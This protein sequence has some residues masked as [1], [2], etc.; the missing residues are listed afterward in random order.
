MKGGEGGGGSGEER[1]CDMNGVVGPMPVEYPLPNSLPCSSLVRL[2]VLSFAIY[3]CST[4]S[5][6]GCVLTHL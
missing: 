6:P 4:G 2:I 5:F 1:R 3:L